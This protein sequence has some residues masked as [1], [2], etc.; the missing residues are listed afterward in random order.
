MKKPEESFVVIC[1]I[2]RNAEKGL[3]NNIPVIDKICRHFGAYQIVVYENDSKDATKRL[4]SEW[5]S[6]NPEHVHAFME[7]YGIQ[8]IPRAESVRCNPFFSLYRNE[9]MSRFRNQYLEY[10][11][12][13][14]W[15]PDYLMVVDLDV[16]KIDIKGVI[17]SFYTDEEWDAITAFGFSLA[18]NMRLR[19]HDTYILV[20]NGEENIRQTELSIKNKAEKFARYYGSENLIPVYSAFGGLAIYKYDRVKGLRYKAMP[21]DDYRVESRGEHF[22]LYKQMNE[23][24]PLAVYI[25]P[26]M[27]I[28]YQNVDLALIWKTLR[29]KVSSSG[30]FCKKQF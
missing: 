14:G 4:L 24:G 1:S 7:D 10:I 8:T 21:N 26:K 9:R 22:S 5:M 20:E 29:R 3:K 13:K 6:Q 12:S 15:D 11:E 28:K 18:P 27:R 17:S 19:Y 23:R 2:V 25:N 16:A 30:V